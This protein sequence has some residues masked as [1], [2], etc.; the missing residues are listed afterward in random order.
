MSK[1]E[2]KIDGI[3]NVE[4]ALGRTEQ[5]IEKNQKVITIVIAAV[6]VVVL[7]YFGYNNY[8]Y[9]P[10]VAEAAAS[11]FQAERY[12]EQD[13]MKLALYGDGNNFGFLYIIDEY[14]GTPA[15]NL[16]KYY[17]GV[18]FLNLG[19]YDNAIKNLNSFSSKDLIVSSLAIGAIGDAYVQKGDVAKGVQYY[20]KAAKN[21]KDKFNTP[22]FLM[23]AGIAY[24]ELGQYAKA[25]EA[26]KKIQSD[27][28]ESREG[29]SIEKYIARVE[30][31]KSK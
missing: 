12:F 25:L 14:S 8:I 15:A 28:A 20:A 23:K 31:L 21:P 13:S 26:Y 30:F 1:K 7:G 24:E 11:M 5:F 3:E 16:A 22:I 2:E 4:Q 9:K 18:A 6:V 17:A 27:F 10:K 29:R 19:Q